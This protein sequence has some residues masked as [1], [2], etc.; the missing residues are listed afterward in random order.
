VPNQPSNPRPKTRFDYDLE[1]ACR[2][3]A[4]DP[5]PAPVAKVIGP[6]L[7]ELTHA[8]K[9]ALLEAA[10]RQVEFSRGVPM[11]DVEDRVMATMI[12]GAYFS[13]CAAAREQKA[14]PAVRAEVI[15]RRLLQRCYLRAEGDQ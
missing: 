1:R 9:L 7:P 14:T 2:K 13:L 3:V 6:Q 10:V 8:E 15:T 4:N 5:G 11:T 12:D